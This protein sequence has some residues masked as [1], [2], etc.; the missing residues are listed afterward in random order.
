MIAA[1][2]DRRW[3]NEMEVKEAEPAAVEVKEAG[4]A[5]VDALGG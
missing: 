4:P 1:I 2:L 3:P 5:A